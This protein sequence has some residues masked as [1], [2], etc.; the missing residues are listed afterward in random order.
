MDVCRARNL[1]YTCDEKRGCRGVLDVVLALLRTNERPGL[2]LLP[3]VRLAFKN[4]GCGLLERRRESKTWKHVYYLFVCKYHSTICMYTG[5]STR[6]V[7]LS[8]CCS[9]STTRFIA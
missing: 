3:P 9:S 7:A 6:M 2:F 1:G 4:G 5:I 8:I